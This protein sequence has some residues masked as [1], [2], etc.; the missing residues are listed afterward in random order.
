MKTEIMWEQLLGKGL[1]HLV[2]N[3]GAHIEVE[4]LAI[5]VLNQV[6]YR[7]LYKIICDLNWSV[8]RLSLLDLLGDK[9][10]ELIRNKH[11]WL[12]GEINPMETFSGCTDIDIMI[13][14]F[15]NTLPLRRL[16]LAPGVAQEISVIYVSIPNLELSKLDQRYTCL[17]KGTN[18]GTYRYENLTSGFTSDLKVDADGL[19][20]DYPGIFQMAWKQAD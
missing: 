10:V 14:P 6:P 17:T 11:G 19:V 5:G 20:V 12:D 2:L 9:K 15:T 16:N 1:E 3:Q 18:G 4:S 8:Q 7:I 13:T